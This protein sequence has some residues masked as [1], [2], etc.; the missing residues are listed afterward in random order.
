LIGRLV[1]ITKFANIIRKQVLTKIV[2]KK[3]FWKGNQY[4]EGYQYGLEFI[5]IWVEGADVGWRTKAGRKLKTID[6]AKGIS[7]VF[8][9][10]SIWIVSPWNL[11]SSTETPSSNALSS[12]SNVVFTFLL[13]NTTLQMEIIPSS[14]LCFIK[15]SSERVVYSVGYGGL[16]YTPVKLRYLLEWV[17]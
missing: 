1:F 2:R 10:D 5:K 3:P 7:R 11:R 8:F 15:K 16:I 6:R 12:S 9:T 13:Y 17:Y 14:G 4:W